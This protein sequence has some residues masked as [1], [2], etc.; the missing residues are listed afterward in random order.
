MIFKI[1]KKTFLLLFVVLLANACQ[2]KKE[3]IIAP[4][5]ILLNHSFSDLQG[6]TVDIKQYL[7]KPLLINYWAT[8]CKFCLKDLP[9]VQQF[10]D[11]HKRGYNVILLS[12]ESVEKIEQFKTRQEY[13]FVYLK[14]DKPLSAYGIRQRP[15][16]AYFSAAGKHLETINGSVDAEILF[17]MVEYHKA[18]EHKMQNKETQ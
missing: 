4:D 10:A 6:N 5:E 17:G 7:G 15:A 9:I 2:P 14:S 18:K 11:Y 1:I 12:D 3:I 16:F 8:W 13:N